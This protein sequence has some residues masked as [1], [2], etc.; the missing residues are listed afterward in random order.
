MKTRYYFVLQ[1]LFFTALI[2]LYKAAVLPIYYYHEFFQDQFAWHRLLIAIAMVF[3][4]TFIRYST[5]EPMLRITIEGMVF[6]AVIPTCA[7]FVYNDMPVGVLVIFLIPMV[8]VS[9]TSRIISNKKF[10]RKS[11]KINNNNAIY[12]VTILIV[13]L[14]P[15]FL[16]MDTANWRNLLFEDIY[17]TR[18]L[19]RVSSSALMSYLAA[20]LAK[21][22]LPILL[23]IALDKKAWLQALFAFFGIIVV[24]LTKGAQKD[25]VMGLLLILF[26]YIVAKKR[27]YLKSLTYLT[28]GVSI[29]AAICSI[30]YKLFKVP[31]ITTYFRRLFFVGPALS[32]RYYEYFSVNSFTY[33]THT[34]IGHYLFGSGERVPLTTWFGA[35]VIGSGVNSN[36]GIFIEGFV[37]FGYIG[38]IIASIVFALICGYIAKLDME[39][40]F[41]GIWITMIYMFYF[42]LLDVLLLTHGLALFLVAAYFI[43]PK[44]SGLDRPTASI[45]V[46]F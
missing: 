10:E 15:F 21:V 33:Y 38:V 28:A 23:I 31:L 6:F 24:F 20:P 1:I 19:S 5:K 26:C 13:L 45:K 2:T 37:S 35:E 29:A 3:A 9:C 18:D 22:L 30:L 14:L 25:I 32:Q 8:A 40:A 7:Y 17:E 46:R 39:P 12:V 36:T 11:F 4:V 43:I 42:S 27:S 16:E 34:R 41:I 44:R